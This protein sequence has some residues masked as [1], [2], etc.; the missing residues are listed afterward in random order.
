[1][2]KVLT[3]LTILLTIIC[4]LFLVSCKEETI[5]TPSKDPVHNNK[6]WFTEAELEK[7]G[8]LGLKAPTNLD[9]E[10]S[11]STTWFNGGYSFSQVCPSEEIFFKNA[12][13]YFEYLKEK[14]VSNPNFIYETVNIEKLSLSTNEIW[15]RF[16][17]TTDLDSYYDDN[18]SKLYKFYY[19]AKNE[20]LDG[21]YKPDAVYILEI[22]YEFDTNRNA[23]CFKLFIENGSKS[24]NG[25][26]TY[27]YKMIDIK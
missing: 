20:V 10:M 18:P 1:M 19:V 15:Y 24:N 9:G 14:R 5:I 26:Y 8:L 22:R 12:N 11:S 13:Q 27:H 16:N 7:V 6:E 17:Q 3:K 21:Y 23:Y 25:V 2:K 4:C